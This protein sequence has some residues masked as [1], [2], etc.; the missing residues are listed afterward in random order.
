MTVHSLATIT[1]KFVVGFVTP[2][3]A[4]T[5]AGCGDRGEPLPRSVTAERTP[6]ELFRQKVARLV[7]QI[8]SDEYRFKESAYALFK[9][10]TGDAAIEC[11]EEL[12]DMYVQAVKEMNFEIEK[13]A[14][15]E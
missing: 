5:T 11:Y 7:G 9:G 6:K 15:A 14:L 8:D 12:T 4:L 13:A 3:L 2:I 10:V 1:L